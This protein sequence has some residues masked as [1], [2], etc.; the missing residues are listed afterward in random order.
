MQFGGVQLGNGDISRKLQESSS[1][2]AAVSQLR[3]VQ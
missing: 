2:E 1:M 3:Y